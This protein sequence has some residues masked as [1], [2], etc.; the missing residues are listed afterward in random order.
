MTYDEYVAQI[1]NFAWV[2]Q[3]GDPSGAALLDAVLPQIIIDAELRMYRDPRLD[4]LAT[5]TTD[6]TQRTQRGIR[7]VPIAPQMV[8]L[9][10]VSLILPANTPPVITGTQPNPPIMPQRVPL[11][12][13]SR[14]WLDLTWPIEAMV[15]TPVPFETYWA[16]F[17]QQET[18]E[19]DDPVP[20]PSAILIGPTVDDVYVVEQT[21]TFRPAPL[22]PTNPTTFIS[23]DLPDLFFSASMV[24]VSAWQRK[25]GLPG[26]QM[27]MSWD[28]HYEME[29][30][31]ASVEEARKKAL[32]VGQSPYTPMPL[33][34]MPR[35]GSPL[36][37]APGAGAPP[38]S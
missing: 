4:F 19:G 27:A 22:S 35:V 33:A 30:R 10:A 25:F 11:L 32:S 14:P 16:L 21:G 23:T 24:L 1:Q 7:S 9:E 29:V 28:Q 6:I 18:A 13:T 12:R 34:G 3:E 8:V 38:G 26:D 31:G 37:S 15:K 36:Q 5:R 17:S 2:G 20:G